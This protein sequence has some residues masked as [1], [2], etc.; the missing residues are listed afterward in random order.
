MATKELS[1]NGT[2]REVPAVIEVLKIGE[3]GVANVATK[4]GTVKLG[5]L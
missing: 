5:L 1:L 2:G 3:C 4:E